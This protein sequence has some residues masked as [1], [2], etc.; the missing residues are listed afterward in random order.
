MTLAG[1]ASGPLDEI[2]NSARKT[3]D[4]MTML[5]MVVVNIYI[6]VVVKRIF[7]FYNYMKFRGQ[8]ASTSVCNSSAIT[9]GRNY[10]YRAHHIYRGLSRRD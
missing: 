3:K 7:R 2:L 1:S 6:K 10:S 8:C 4:F 5:Y 9:Y